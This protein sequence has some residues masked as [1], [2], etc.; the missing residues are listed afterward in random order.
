[1]LFAADPARTV[2]CL[3]S[4]ADAIARESKENLP[5][6]AQLDDLAYIIYT[7]G[8]T[9]WPKGVVMA[10]RGPSALVEWARQAFP[11]QQV[12]GI[13]CSSSICF[14]MSV[15]DLFFAFARGSKLILVEN[16]LELPACP[17]AEEVTFIQTIPSAMN[18]LI[19]MKAVPASLR[20]V[21]LGGEA[22]PAG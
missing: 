17:H 15:F 5:P 9:G 12:A 20:A 2:L 21:M 11:S 1:P 13:L 14:D 19:H 7:S 22:V 18:E 6:L 8:S 4:A 16:I 10:H 3:Q